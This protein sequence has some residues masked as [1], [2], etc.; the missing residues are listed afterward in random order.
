MQK[1]TDRFVVLTV[2]N[3]K[4]GV[5][6]SF[7][8]KMLAEYAA[9]RLGLSTLI[10]DLDP[11][12][13][14]SKRYIAMERIPHAIEDYIPP[15]H[16]SWSPEEVGWDGRSS[17][18]DIWDAESGVVVP[19]PTSVP[20]LDILPGHAQRLEDIERVLTH[21]VWIKVAERL[22]AFL[23]IPEIREAYDLVVVDTRPSKGPLTT[24]GVMA[25][26]HL[27]IPTEMEAPSVE[28]LYGMISLQTQV[29]LRR[30][31]H[32]Q[33]N[34]IG[35]L[36]NKVQPT[37]LHRDFMAMLKEDPHVRALML[38]E[39][40]GYRTDFKKSMLSAEEGLF[41]R[42]GSNKAREE[43]EHLCLAVFRRVYGDYFSHVAAGMECAA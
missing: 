2:G 25:A 27:L 4:G 17:S 21:D 14:I 12:T 26:T 13:N 32:D 28:G 33:V 41:M 38:E 35:I 20:R 37:L 24:S 31:R 40:L 29:N 6:K 30:P 5:G 11:Q 15:V 7:L 18:A 39:V 36:A 10:I 23:S 19:Y 9:L 22:R 43:A 1:K 42:S 34:L 3:N 16:P 8:S